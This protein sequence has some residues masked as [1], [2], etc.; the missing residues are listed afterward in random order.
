MVNVWTW[1]ESVCDVL[2]VYEHE[3]DEDVARTHVH[4]YMEGFTLTIEGLKA[5]IRR[6][7]DASGL[8]A[9][10]R[11]D[12]SFKEQNKD[13]TPVD[14]NCIVYMTK[15]ELD[16]KRTKGVT[17]ETLAHYKAR[18]IERP[19]RTE[20]VRLQMVVKESPKEAKKRKNDFIVEMRALLAERCL[21]FRYRHRPANTQVID[22]IIDVLNRNNV[23]FGRYNIR[24]YF[25]TMMARER[26]QR[27][28]EI[29]ENFCGF[30][31]GTAQAP[32]SYET[33]EFHAGSL[34]C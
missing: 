26:P 11:S 29:M 12:W 14:S 23:V 16:A 33:P 25:D 2:V 10:A 24:E 19:K 22:A 21:D 13:K 32:S 8:G 15:G 34:P 17:D 5:C 31:N 18:W 4:F 7:M 28:K 27:F 20:Q 6:E 3:K 30:Q 1:L 9:M